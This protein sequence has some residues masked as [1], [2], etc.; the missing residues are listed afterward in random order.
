MQLQK[1]FCGHILVALFHKLIDITAIHLQSPDLGQGTIPLI[2]GSREYLLSKTPEYHIRQHS[3]TIAPSNERGFSSQTVASRVTHLQP[4]RKE[5][6]RG[7]FK[8]VTRANSSGKGS[9]DNDYCF[10]E[11]HP[12]AT[13]SARKKKGEYLKM[14]QEQRLQVKDPVIMTTVSSRGIHLQ[15]CQQGGNKANI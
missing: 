15:P 8:D 14:S 1:L 7:I 12:S 4:V 6:A 13:M 11:R 2:I 9:S 3:P 5:E 10:F